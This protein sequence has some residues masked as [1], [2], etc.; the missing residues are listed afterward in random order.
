MFLKGFEWYFK[1]HISKKTLVLVSDMVKKL[2]AGTG[3]KSPKTSRSGSGKKVAD[4]NPQ[5]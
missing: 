2:G 5:L 4:L 1:T 3:I